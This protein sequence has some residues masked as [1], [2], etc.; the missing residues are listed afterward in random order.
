MKAINQ[1]AMI[2][3]IF[4]I[5]SICAAAPA[6]VPAKYDFDN[7][8]EQVSEVLDTHFDEWD[9]VDDQ[10]FILQT[11]PSEYYLI[12][13]RSPSDDLPFSD[14]V[15]I[16]EKNSIIKVGK[17]KVITTDNGIENRYVISK[18]YKI[19]DSDQAEKIRAQLIG[20][21]KAKQ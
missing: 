4:F 10:S 6:K 16:G 17:S 7:Q 19:K 9:K 2:F 14:P 15:K 21:R 11:S 12:I 20:P 5:A 1:F 3:A 8:L 13:L 18:I